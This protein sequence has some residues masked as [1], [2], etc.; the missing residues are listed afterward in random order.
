MTLLSAIVVGFL[1]NGVLALPQLFG[2]GGFG[3]E[4]M[5][6]LSAS[7]SPDKLGHFMG[8][9]AATEGLTSLAKLFGATRTAPGYL[10]YWTSAVMNGLSLP[11]FAM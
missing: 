2:G 6:L 5:Q 11:S 3:P 9:V 1:S 8:E 4:M 7:T 10:Q